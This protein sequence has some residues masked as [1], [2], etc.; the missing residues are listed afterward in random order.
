M[1]LYLPYSFLSV[2]VIW[3]PPSLPNSLLFALATSELL[4]LLLL[5]DYTPPKR[6]SERAES[7]NP[8]QKTLHR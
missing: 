1:S 2:P 5:L 3:S 7:Y 8:A 6:P 4:L